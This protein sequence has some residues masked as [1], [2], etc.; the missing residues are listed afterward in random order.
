MVKIKYDGKE[1]T[2]LLL[3]F[4]IWFGMIFKC[5]NKLLKVFKGW[6]IKPIMGLMMF[7]KKARTG[8]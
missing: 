6:A 3:F 2:V 7:I 8:I 4:S 1:R 5:S